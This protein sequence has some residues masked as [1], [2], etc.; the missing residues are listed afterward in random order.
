MQF[1]RTL[2]DNHVDRAE[3]PESSLILYQQA[4]RCE[5][6]GDIKEASI[7]F[8]KILGN[9]SDRAIYAGAH[10]HLGEICFMQGRKMDA[11]EH[12][13]E[14]LKKYPYHRKAKEYLIRYYEVHETCLEQFNDIEKSNTLKVTD[15]IVQE[16]RLA[17]TFLDGLEGIEI[18]ASAY[19]PFGLKTLNVGLIDEIYEDE[20]FKRAGYI[21]P[22]DI[23]APADNIPLATECMDFVLA[24]HVLEHCKDFIGTVLEWFRVIKKGGFLYIIFPRSDASAADS[25]K[26]L[27]EWRDIFN[28]YREN[29]HD[30]NHYELHAHFHVLDGDKLKGIMTKIFGDRVELISEQPIDDKVGNGFTLVYKKKRYYEASFP[31]VLNNESVL[32]TLPKEE[33]MKKGFV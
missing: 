3:R 20:Q 7:L 18:G 4:S 11:K 17:H 21:C 14:C 29:E 9:T 27:S 15:Q 26:P 1:V 22:I 19:N 28:T 6:R 2:A 25:K 10:F 32:L 24:S 33:S 8:N 16:S 23:V 13:I 5:K 31:W 12:F 30:I